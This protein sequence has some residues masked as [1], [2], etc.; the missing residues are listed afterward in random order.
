MQDVVEIDYMP[1]LQHHLEY[2]RSTHEFT[3]VAET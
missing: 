3:L 2:T 1:Y